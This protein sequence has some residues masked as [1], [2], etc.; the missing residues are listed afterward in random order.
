V[1][2]RR[3]ALAALVT[4]AAALSAAAGPPAAA[5]PAQPLPAEA[6][7]L[8][9][10]SLLIAVAAAG[11]RLVAVG[12]RG[13]IVYSDDRG[14]RWAQAARVPVQ[15]LLTGVCFFDAR[16]GLAVGH[17]EVILATADAGEHWQLVHDAPAAQRP[18]L[19]VWCGA[20]GAAIAV[21]AYSSYFTSADGGASW[22]E[23]AFAPSPA[24]RTP[25]VTHADTAQA[26]DTAAGGGYHLNRIVGAAARLYIAAEAGHLYRSDDAGAHWRELASP[27][28]GSFFDVLPLGGETL[29]ACGMRGNLYRSEDGGASWHHLETGTV[30]MLDGAALLPGGAI[31]VVGLSGV[32][33]V[34]RDGAASFTLEQQ[35]DRSGLS[36]AVAVG[37]Q[38]LAVVGEDG[39]RMLS[40]GAG[41]ATAAAGH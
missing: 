11:N 7:R 39:A 25:G 15:A 26:A 12:D 13:I 38:S 23:R 4:A 32:V 40:L 27:Y 8:A 20:N 28:A 10:H 21:G 35:S 6:A 36:A 22:S 3:A 2:Y 31:A 30:A 5:V 1:E 17:D 37:P 24:P 9:A 16:H 41:G 33:L 29:L 14:L 19:D 18:L 34:S